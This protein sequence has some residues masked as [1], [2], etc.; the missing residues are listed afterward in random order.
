MPTPSPFDMISDYLNHHLSPE[1]HAFFEQQ[2]QD[3]KELQ[4]MVALEQR[5][6]NNSPQ[7]LVSAMPSFGD[8]DERLNQRE[9]SFWFRTAIPALAAC[10]VAV[11]GFLL[12]PG[13]PG[14]PHTSA[15][16][17]DYITLSQQSP[18]SVDVVRVIAT[19]PQA[20][21]QLVNDYQ[22]NVMQAYPETPVIDLASTPE[23][24][25]LIS[26]AEKD[27]RIIQAQLLKAAE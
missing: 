14:Q 9:H 22:L 23:A 3:N 8:L 13:A 17:A 25:K 21:Q 10:F 11:V 6:K 27:A 7:P 24:L 26:I 15:V 12:L 2:L 18:R 16:P 20:L 5:I 4:K 19:N 1:E